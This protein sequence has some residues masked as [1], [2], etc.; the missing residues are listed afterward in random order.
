MTTALAPPEQ[1]QVQAPAE[2]TTQR[3]IFIQGIFRTGGTYLWF[4]FR[5]LPGYRAYYEPL[6]EVLAKPEEDVRTTVNDFVT[7]ARH[8]RAD[9]YF[10]EFPFRI[11][12]G[13]EYFHESFSLESYALAENGFDEP[14]RRYMTHLLTYSLA[15]QQIPVFKFDRASLRAGWLTA[16]FSPINLLVLRNPR[17]VWESFRSFGADDPFKTIFCMTLGRNRNHPLLGDLANRL[18]LPECPFVATAKV[19]DC[20]RGW[21]GQIGDALYPFFFEFYV[22][23][24]LHSARYAD[25]VLDMTGI[26][27]NPVLKTAA[28]SRLKELHI[29]ISLDDCRMPSAQISEVIRSNMTSIENDCLARLNGRLPEAFLIPEQKWAL[30]GPSVSEYFGNIFS[31]F[32]TSAAVQFALADTEF[33]AEAKKQE[34]LRLISTG[35]TLQGGQLLSEILQHEQ[36]PK[37]WE[38][39]AKAQIANSHLVSAAAG[40]RRAAEFSCR[41]RAPLRRVR[42]VLWERNLALV[43]MLANKGIVVRRF[44][45]RLSGKVLSICKMGITPNA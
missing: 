5:K 2:A 36:T 12:G 31:R 8:P 30:L 25:C 6:N 37:L 26:S 15:H 18:G 17:D 35:H 10:A 44:L 7:M 29:P 9:F 42:A 45:E 21:T 4:K 1:Q 13:V 33:R 16:N 20:Y 32:Q 43:R 34:V 22:L 27:S 39:W 24:I 11:G 28:T 19:F 3:P 38:Q 14:L 23:T 40:L 41:R